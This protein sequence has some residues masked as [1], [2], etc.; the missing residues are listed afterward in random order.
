[1]ACAL[2]SWLG[3]SCFSHTLLPLPSILTAQVRCSFPPE[4]QPFQTVMMEPPS[5]VLTTSLAYSSEPPPKV[6]LQTRL[7][8]RSILASQASYPQ[9]PPVMWPS[10]LRVPP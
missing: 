1:M 4:S 9:R 6:V 3:V 5:G 2:A 7:P 8:E 10:T